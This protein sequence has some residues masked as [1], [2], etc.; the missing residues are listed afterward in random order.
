MAAVI[1][2]KTT[3]ERN[4]SFFLLYGEMIGAA[5]ESTGASTAIVISPA[6]RATADRASI[7]VAL[8][9]ERNTASKAIAGYMVMVI[10]AQRQGE[11]EWAPPAVCLNIITEIR[12]DSTPGSTPSSA[13]S[14]RVKRVLPR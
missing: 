9:C 4:F 8:S 10:A 1:T 2:A 7:S 6:R 11:L 14:R 3:S 13:A 12:Q 5:R